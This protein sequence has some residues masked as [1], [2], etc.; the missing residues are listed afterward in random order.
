MASP[1][2]SRRSSTLKGDRG[3]ARP[4][5]SRVDRRIRWLGRQRVAPTPGTRKD[6]IHAAL[7]ALGA[8]GSTNGGGGIIAGGINRVVLCTDGDWNVGITDQGSLTRLIEDERDHGVFLT[9]LGFGMGNLKDSTMEKLADRGN[10]DTRTSIRSRRR[11]R[12]WSSRPARRWRPSRR[13]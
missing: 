4:S 7:R 8:N 6:A 10:G 13:T 2:G 3:T 5:R 12:C 1:R 9:V 11:A